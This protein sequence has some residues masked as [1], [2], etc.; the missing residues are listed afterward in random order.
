VA[1]GWLTTAVDGREE[2][3]DDVDWEK[4]TDREEED[5]RLEALLAHL[6]GGCAVESRRSL[7][8]PDRS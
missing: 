5:E 1:A 2:R 6:R 8:R 7:G 3:G 4:L